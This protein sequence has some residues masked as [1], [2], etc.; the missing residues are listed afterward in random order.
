[1]KGRG[2][3]ALL[4]ETPCVMETEKRS[5]SCRPRAW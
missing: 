3:T 2:I 1:M 4:L 5:D